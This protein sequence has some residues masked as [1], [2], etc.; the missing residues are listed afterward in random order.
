MCKVKKI[1]ISEHYLK[2]FNLWNDTAYS[3]L[4]KN[5]YLRY[6]Q[7]EVNRAEIVAAK[8]FYKSLRAPGKRVL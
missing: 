8:V 7:N 3:P 1:I 2:R 6:L 4:A 5:F